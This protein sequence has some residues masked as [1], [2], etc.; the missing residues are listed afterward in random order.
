MPARSGGPVFPSPANFSGKIYASLSGLLG[1]VTRG[2]RGGSGLVGG[3]GGGAFLVF[4]R[5]Q[6][7]L[8]L[9]QQVPG[10]QRLDE[11]RLRALALPVAAQRRVRGQDGSGGIVGLLFGRADDVVAGGFG[12]P[13]A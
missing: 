13:R 4:V 10:V 7:R 6:Q 3:D 2:P 5:D 11:Q 9:P 1:L 12:F 8:D